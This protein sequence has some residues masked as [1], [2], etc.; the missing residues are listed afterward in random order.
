MFV[1]QFAAN[2]SELGA[3][4][5]LSIAAVFLAMPEI[6][7][8]AK[9]PPTL[10]MR[11]SPDGFLERLDATFDFAGD[12]INAKGHAPFRIGAGFALPFEAIRICRIAI[13]S[14]DA[15]HISLPIDANRRAA[16]PVVG[17]LRFADRS[18]MVADA[19]VARRFRTACER[20]AAVY[21]NGDQRHHHDAPSFTHRPQTTEVSGKVLV[22]RD[23]YS[24]RQYAVFLKTTVIVTVCILMV[25]GCA[26]LDRYSVIA[27][28]A[29]SRRTGSR[30]RRC[31]DPRSSPPVQRSARMHSSDVSMA[32]LL[33]P[34]AYPGDDSQAGRQPQARYPIGE[35]HPP[36]GRESRYRRL[37][38][39]RRREPF[40][41]QFAIQT[42]GFV[43]QQRPCAVDLSPIAVNVADG[44]S[45]R[46]SSSYFGVRQNRNAS[47]L[48]LTASSTASLSRSKYSS[49]ACASPDSAFNSDG[50]K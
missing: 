38:N 11:R 2:Y 42:R 8:C 1:N 17:S 28:L 16:G 27:P 48:A 7:R 14:K 20:F 22:V 26:S 36:R 13:V 34:P 35:E 12:Q 4:W 33:I 10:A 46:V 6:C 45:N 5:S 32:A 3:D 23:T 44:H 25:A 15:L 31:E 29:R 21:R 40:M 30:A 18:S 39:P 24:L 37:R 47:P 9:Q 41:A 50:R 19:V 43:A 49:H